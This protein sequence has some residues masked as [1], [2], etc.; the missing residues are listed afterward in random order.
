MTYDITG[1]GLTVARASYS[2]YYGQMAPG[3]LSSVISATGQVM[4]RYGWQDLNG[5]TI[6]TPNEVNFGT[7]LARSAAYDP[8]NPA[9]FLSPGT[10][11]PDVKND[12]TREFIVGLDREIMPGLGVGAAYI[13]RKYDRFFW[14]DNV[15]LESDDYVPVQY[16]PAASSCPAGSRCQTVTY[17]QP[18]FPIPAA[19]VYTNVPDRYRD[20][21]GFELTLR[22]RYSN[23]WQ[24]NFSY[25]FN[26]AVDHWD[27][28]ASYQ[29]PTNIDK[30]N[31]AQYAPESGGSGIDNVF[32]N[33]KWLVKANGIY[34]LPWYDIG[35]AGN[36]NYRQG[37]PFPQSILSP[38]RANQA[39]QIQIL[40]D[41]LGDV[42]L[43]NV[44]TVDF[45]VD[46]TFTFRTVKVVPSM[47]VFNV[48]N[49]NTI[50]AQ[51]RNQAASN[52]NQISGIV[53]PRVIR[54]GFRV[55]W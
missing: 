36:L 35:L 23:R 25:A 52:A 22:K 48:T 42:R 31:N 47:D 55:Q 38:N 2:T 19:Y 28:P 20:F 49:E 21:N 24:A 41:P 4:V 14:N 12:R 45:R 15:G 43:P 5:D 8:A 33:A 34:T 17:Y 44:Y 1:D 16:T 10:V 40:L 50:L 27:S 37:Y 3:Q 18:T 6:V 46:N 32:N 29:D 26:T 51:R 11:D 54:F 39:G 7:I 13:W 30:W 53:A 9:N